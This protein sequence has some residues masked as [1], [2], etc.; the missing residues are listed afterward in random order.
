VTPGSDRDLPTN[1]M[2]GSGSDGI[3]AQSAGECAAIPT[4][5]LPWKGPLNEANEG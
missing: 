5:G 2:H 4:A 3:E 1:I